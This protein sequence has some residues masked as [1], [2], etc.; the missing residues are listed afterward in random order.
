MGVTPPTRARPV[1]AITLMAAGGVGL[2]LGGVFA[3]LRATALDGC[4]VEGDVGYCRGEAARQEAESAPAYATGATVGFLAGGALLAGG[5]VWLI[6]DA[7][8]TTPSRERAL[9]PVVGPGGLGLLGR[10]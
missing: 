4:R 6:L 5:A 7:I 10:F 8:P 2:V 3:G 1:G 9:L